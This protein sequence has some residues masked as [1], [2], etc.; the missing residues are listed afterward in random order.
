VIGVNACSAATKVVDV[1]AFRDR[2]LVDEV[3]GPMCTH[4]SAVQV[5]SPVPAGVEAALPDPTAAGFGDVALGQP[6]GS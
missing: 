5:E 4:S 3:S 6:G 1:E 2:T